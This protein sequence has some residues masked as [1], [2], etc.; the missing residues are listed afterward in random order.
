[1]YLYDLLRYYLHG[2][3]KR[4]KRPVNYSILSSCRAT[5]EDFHRVSPD[6]FINSSRPKICQQLLITNTLAI[7]VA[8]E[9]TARRFG[10][11]F[12]PLGQRYGPIANR[13]PVTGRIEQ[14]PCACLVHGRRSQIGEW[15]ENPPHYQAQEPCG[16]PREEGCRHEAGVGMYEADA[17]ILPGEMLVG[18][19]KHSSR[20]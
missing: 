18:Q 17:R 20:V 2:F 1:M 19:R 13:V 12:H 9:D 7:G 10:G 15:L 16:S 6:L 4:D 14:G 5:I 8:Q 3:Y 11:L